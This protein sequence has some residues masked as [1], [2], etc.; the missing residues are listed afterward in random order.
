VLPDALSLDAALTDSVTAWHR[1]DSE[2]AVELGRVL[3]DSWRHS[4]EGGI[5]L[6]LGYRYYRP[7]LDPDEASS[8]RDDI[9][10][11]T[12]QGYLLLGYGYHF[13]HLRGSA[14]QLEIKYGW[15]RFTEYHSPR[16]FA[17][18]WSVRLAFVKH[19]LRLPGG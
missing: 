3:I 5:G 14:L 7:V 17:D 8:Q 13:G 1:T 19:Q 6:G 16:W 18:D 12:S 4:L 15:G 9:G 10:I 11:Q 2:I